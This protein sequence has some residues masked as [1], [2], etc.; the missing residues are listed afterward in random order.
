MVRWQCCTELQD[1]PVIQYDTVRRP[2]HRAPCQ[3]IPIRHGWHKDCHSDT[4]LRCPLWGQGGGWTLTVQKLYLAAIC[5]NSILWKGGTCSINNVSELPKI[6]WIP[7]IKDYC[8]KW[9][10]C[11]SAWNWANCALAYSHCFLLFYYKNCIY[12]ILDHIG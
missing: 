7:Q 12:E 10:V 11:I 5:R 9:I 8:I 4:G 3:N 2:P 6:C 1:R